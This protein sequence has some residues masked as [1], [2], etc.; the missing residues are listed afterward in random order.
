MF[1]TPETAELGLHNF[2]KNKVYN[3]DVAGSYTYPTSV[4]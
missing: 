1:M 4:I 2:I 3:E